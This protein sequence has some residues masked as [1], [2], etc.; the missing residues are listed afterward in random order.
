M[1]SFK[2]IVCKYYN[3][4]W[5]E[6]VCLYKTKVVGDINVNCILKIP[7]DVSSIKQFISGNLSSDA[8]RFKR[9]MN[10]GMR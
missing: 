8:I 3:P 5:L 10:E 7:L 1:R 6:V 4:H 9:N 2:F